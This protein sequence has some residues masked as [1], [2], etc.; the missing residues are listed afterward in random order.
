MKKNKYFNDTPILTPEDDRFGANNFAEVLSRSIIGFDSP[1]GATIALNGSWGSGKS[2]TINLIRHHIALTTKKNELEIV[3]FK[4]WWFRGE[5]A[6][7][8][9][10]LQELDS[11]LKKSIRKK[12]KK[13]IPKI[14]KTLLQTGQVIGPIIN[15][16][17]GG[18]WGSLAKGSMDFIKNYFPE[19]DS[20]ESLFLQLSKELESLNKKF[21]V[22]IDDIDRLSPE[23]ALLIFRLI[24]SV[25]RLPN[26]M[27]LLAFDRNLAEKAVSD[28]YPSEGPH[29]LEKIIQAS[30]DLPLP[31]KDDLNSAALIQIDSLCGSSKEPEEV[32]RFMNIFYDTVAPYLNTPRDLTRLINTMSIS[33]LAVKNEVNL[34]DFVALEVL[35]LFESKL[36]NALKI[37]K[38]QICGIRS[39]YSREEKPEE[40]L[41]EFL[42]HVPEKRKQQGRLSLLRL[43]PR[44]ENIDYADSFISQWESERRV[45]TNKCFGIYFRMSISDDI[46]SSKEL[47]EFIDNAHN[48][49]YI[50]DV[51]K[52]H[53]CII[54][55]NGRSNIP[56]FFDE[57]NN[58]AHKIKDNN[59]QIIISAIFEIADDINREEDAERGFSIGD[60]YLRIHWLIRKFT[61]ERFDLPIRSKILMDA[62][63]KAQLGWRIDFTASAMADYFPREGKEPE[64]SEKCLTTEESIPELK[65]SIITSIDIL[66]KD[67]SLIDFPRL[68]YVLFR[69]EEFLDDNEKEKVKKWTTK[70]I[71]N[72]LTLSKLAKAFTSVTW[73]HSMGMFGLGDRVSIKKNRAAIDNIDR[74]ID[75]PLFRHQ[76]EKI[77]NDNELDETYQAYIKDFL[78]AWR[79]REC[80][81]D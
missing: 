63:K 41:K 75:K 11:A 6:L 22:I 8:L 44:L 14:S 73:S 43:F 54:R 57:L 38:D 62:C 42:E 76:L 53:L 51:F 10:F 35:R 27:Y 3:D 4:C 48:K 9:A 15:M 81:E 68:L 56:L 59:I 71:S 23:E 52:K 60:T 58:N 46:I 37:N 2:S 7:T 30:F 65:H 16:S 72:N 24:K 47:E 77:E 17:S 34:A 79:D 64:P 67:E 26:V 36:F 13:L 70:Q 80:G 50:K 32:K 28:F 31:T 25:G 33:W 12:A 61:F 18:I 49:E 20:I 39:N 40:V 21:L 45:C 29:F 55:K 5:E 78:K 19:G 66:V 1:I 74:I 69:W